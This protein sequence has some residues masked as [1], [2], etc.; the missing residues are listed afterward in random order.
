MN[1]DNKDN[2]QYNEQQYASKDN[3]EPHPVS[4]D[5]RYKVLPPRHFGRVRAVDLNGLFV[6]F[7]RKIAYVKRN[8]RFA[9]TVEREQDIR[10]AVLVVI[11]QRFDLDRL[12]RLDR[13]DKTHDVAIVEIV[14]PVF[15]INLYRALVR[16]VQTADRIFVR[17]LT[18]LEHR[19]LVGH[20]LYR[21]R[22]LANNL[23]R[24]KHD[25]SINRSALGSAVNAPELVGRQ[26]R[27][28]G[29]YSALAHAGGVNADAAGA[30][31]FHAVND[32]ALRVLL[33]Q[34]VFHRHCASY[35][36][37]YFLHRQYVG[38]VVERV[39]NDNR[40]LKR[41]HF[42]VEHALRRAVLITAVYYGERNF[43]LAV[44]ACRGRDSEFLVRV[45]IGAVCRIPP[46]DR[47][48][49]NNRRIV[50]VGNINVQPGSVNLGLVHYILGGVHQNFVDKHIRSA[51]ARVGRVRRIV[52]V[53]ID[54]RYIIENIERN[55]SVGDCGGVGVQ[56]HAHNGDGRLNV[57][58]SRRR[59]V[60]DGNAHGEY[61]RF[62]FRNG[63]ADLQFAD[64]NRTALRGF[65][66]KRNS[67]QRRNAV[68]VGRAGQS[69]GHQRIAVAVFNSA[70]SVVNAVGRNRARK[71][72]IRTHKTVGAIDGEQDVS[73]HIQVGVV[74]YVRNIDGQRRA[75]FELGFEHIA[76]GIR[77]RHGIAELFN[78]IR[79]G[80]GLYFGYVVIDAHFDFR[81]NATLFVIAEPDRVRAVDL[82]G[83]F[84]I[85][86]F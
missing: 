72:L 37:S 79:V 56:A 8:V 22:A 17:G 35:A 31:F 4:L 11:E 42:S 1:N 78:L 9:A 70:Y 74:D 58:F 55:G 46:I 28:R 62:G 36:V 49:R 21:E 51:F 54:V 81:R 53:A 39:G 27:C 66:S 20:D 10:S 82:N 14:E 18:A 24:F 84:G 63:I 65:A 16:V 73:I 76:L 45:S 26:G 5:K 67:A 61:A 69:Y 43:L 47:T 75:F 38:D 68:S 64:G 3:P 6:K 7:A 50:F 83:D 23:A 57:G 13:A 80:H 44:N 12:R 48:N 25:L 60:I 77:V 2:Q 19:G 34:Q 59:N 52:S 86:I 85:R 30:D 15:G 71:I 33:A 41:E 32:I 29:G 40:K